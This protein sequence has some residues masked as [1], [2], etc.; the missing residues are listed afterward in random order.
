MWSVKF[1]PGYWVES[2]CAYILQGK[3]RNPRPDEGDPTKGQLNKCERKNELNDNPLEF[4]CLS[5]G[6]ICIRNVRHSDD[7]HSLRNRVTGDL[8]PKAASSAQ[9]RAKGDLERG[10]AGSTLHGGALYLHAD[11]TWQ[12]AQPPL[13]PPFAPAAWFGDTV[14]W[15][16]GKRQFS[17]QSCC[18]GLRCKTRRPADLLDVELPSLLTSC[19]TSE[20]WSKLLITYVKWA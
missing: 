5:K 7:A 20:P 1:V 8:K 17:Y 19:P 10:G 9:T 4:R 14:T 16:C 18:K 15:P 3:G 13:P 2:L 11:L 12:A 6:E